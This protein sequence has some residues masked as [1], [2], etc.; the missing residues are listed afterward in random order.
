MKIVIDTDAG[1]VA[2]EDGGGR[3]VAGLY[4]A[5][6]FELLSREWLRVGWTQRHS[7]GFTWL[8]RPIIQLPEDVLRAQ[9]L[10]YTL[11]PD[12]IVETGIAHG[13]SLVFYASVCKL[14]GSGRVIGVDVEI[15]PHNRSA[16]EAHPLSPLITLIEGDSVAPEVVARV[17]GLLRPDDETVLVL[18]DS[19]H[20]RAHVLAE[21]EAYA[22]LVTPGSY[23]VAADGG[24]MELL[25]GAPGARPD[26]GW[27]NPKAA[28]AEFV[29]RNPGYVLEEPPPLF[30]E[31]LTRQRVSYWAGGYVRRVK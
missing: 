10:I 18:L 22:P 9:E 24:V 1:T 5:R 26:W 29:R 12:V 25:A 20:T 3:E 30:D 17:K 28:A 27:N 21:L 8:G 11:R 14:L 19:N 7:Y 4:T 2:C 31:G 6:A 13:G 23:A 16:I 15:R